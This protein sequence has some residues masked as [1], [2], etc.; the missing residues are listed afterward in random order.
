MEGNVVISRVLPAIENGWGEI[1]RLRGRVIAV[2]T[3]AVLAAGV[4]LAGCTPDQLDTTGNLRKMSAETDKLNA[5]T[6]ELVALTS[7]M[8]DKEAEMAT[9]VELMDRVVSQ[10]DYQISMTELLTPPNRL[11]EMKTAIILTTAQLV[12]AENLKM[13]ARTQ[14][15]C[16]MSQAALDLI[17]HLSS[18]MDYFEQLNNELEV[19]MQK[20][21]EAMQ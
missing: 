16:D 5:S 7:E 17:T 11:Q 14:G 18:S 6:E 20:I 2:I 21:L 12:L 4:L 13:L 15:Q 8:N 3:L 10:T 1:L 9:S 19:K